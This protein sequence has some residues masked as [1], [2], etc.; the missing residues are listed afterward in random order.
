MKRIVFEVAFITN[1]DIDEYD[2]RDIIYKG[3]DGDE[4]IEGFTSK[5]I[6]KEEN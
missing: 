6:L 1:E 2:F 5:M 4:N 3:T